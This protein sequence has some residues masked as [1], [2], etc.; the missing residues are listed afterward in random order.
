MV[1]RYLFLFSLCMVSIRIFILL[2][3]NLLSKDIV[4]YDVPYEPVN[5]RVR[6][7]SQQ[8][9]GTARQRVTS[10]VS[11]TQNIPSRNAT[12]NATYSSY[13]NSISR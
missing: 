10:S 11:R 9:V 3:E 1:A 12:R 4:D 6:R 2:Y 5:H 13:R 7:E 8:S